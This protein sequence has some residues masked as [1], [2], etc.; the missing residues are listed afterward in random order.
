MKR[1]FIILSGTPEVQY[2]SG[3][4][5]KEKNIRLENRNKSFR[6]YNTCVFEKPQGIGSRG[7]RER[8]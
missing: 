5:R 4:D 8:L 2:Y 3:G 6:R 1:I 7:F